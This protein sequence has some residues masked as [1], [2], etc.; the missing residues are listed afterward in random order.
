VNGQAA[1]GQAASVAT[2]IGKKEAEARLGGLLAFVP[3]GGEAYDASVLP[4]L[5]NDST[6]PLTTHRKRARNY[7]AAGHIFSIS[8]WI[9]Y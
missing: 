2:P 1:V 6:P 5:L 4:Q 8:L 3:T 7:L 9:A